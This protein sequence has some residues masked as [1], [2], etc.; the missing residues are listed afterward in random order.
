M[1][2]VAKMRISH[3]AA[4]WLGTLFIIITIMLPVYFDRV[5]GIDE[6][7]ATTLSQPD[8]VN[9]RQYDVISCLNL[10]DRC[11]RPLTLL[12]QIRTSLTPDTGRLI[13]AVVLPFSSYVET[14]E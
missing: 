7:S 13:L 3:T 9:L 6:W 11:E 5:L 14:S 2:R 1:R 12:Q 10:L 4:V 8:S